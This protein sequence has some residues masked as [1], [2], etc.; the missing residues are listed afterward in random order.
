MKSFFFYEM[1]YRMKRVVFI[2]HEH[3]YLIG[4]SAYADLYV[5]ALILNNILVKNLSRRDQTGKKHVYEKITDKMNDFFLVFYYKIY[6]FLILFFFFFIVFN[7][8]I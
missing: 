7:K 2:K 5:N 8:R 6:E 3:R 1:V 4:K